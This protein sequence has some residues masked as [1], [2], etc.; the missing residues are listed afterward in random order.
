[1]D[2]SNKKP[3][4]L[5]NRYISLTIVLGLC[6]IAFV[7]YSYMSMATT[8]LAVTSAYEGIL[9]KQTQLENVRKILLSIYK[10]IDL[11]LL[12]PLNE[13]LTQRIDKQ[14]D[15]ALTNLNNLKHTR[16]GFDENLDNQLNRAAENFRTLNIEVKNLITYRL[17]IN[18]QYPGMSLSA[19]VMEP[20][21]D[22][23]K[24]SFEILINEI[25]SGEVRF[26]SPETYPLLLKSY[27]IWINA[28]SQ[29]RIYM[30]NRLA[31]YST[32]ILKDQGKSLGDIYR[33][34]LEKLNL[35]TELYAYSDSFE[36]PELL[37]KMIKTTD[38]W[39][40]QFLKLREISESGQWRTDVVIMK[41]NILPLV[42]DI[43][44]DI[45]E[46]GSLLN[47]EKTKTDTALSEVNDSFQQPDFLDYYAF[48]I[49]H[50]RHAGFYGL[51][52]IYTDYTGIL[53]TAFQDLRY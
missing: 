21:Q 23:I 35:L 46:A 31:S 8:K 29:T 45:D 32:E 10:N 22:F 12:D 28:I 17:D 36:G 43:N 2:A 53:R 3:P 13:E 44:A 18:K 50:Y 5:R 24:S 25:E 9:H 37:R 15:M 39:H 34:F 1:M 14:T 16:H 47:T 7:S 33:L 48:S 42:H 11:F 6:V 51:A 30:S 19:N 4:S 49:I 38:D 26:A 41:N 52:G 40:E 27:G 20:Q